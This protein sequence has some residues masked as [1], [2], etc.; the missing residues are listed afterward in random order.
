LGPFDHLSSGHAYEK[1][2]SDPL[3]FCGGYAPLYSIGWSGCP[4]NVIILVWCR[5]YMSVVKIAH[6]EAQF[7]LPTGI[8]S[9]DGCRERKL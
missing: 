4:P 6:V 1:V 2:S 5:S 7:P 8:S 9:F 3:L